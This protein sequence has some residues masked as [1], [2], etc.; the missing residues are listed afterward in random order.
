MTNKAGSY[1]RRTSPIDAN[2]K[3]PVQQA[4]VARCLGL[5]LTLLISQCT[6]LHWTEDV[7]VIQKL[8]KEFVW[9]GE[10][11][12]TKQS[13][14]W[15]LCYPAQSSSDS[16]KNGVKTRPQNNVTGEWN[17][18]GIIFDAQIKVVAQLCLNMSLF[19]LWLTLPR[20]RCL[21]F[22]HLNAW[23]RQPARPRVQRVLF[24]TWQPLASWTAV[25][26]ALC[27]G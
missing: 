21:F 18:H 10:G 2:R 3:D 26:L 5:Y 12:D 6:V 24:A 27:W 25:W 1:T 7:A 16:R 23:R 4:D 17:E 9:R 20:S 22:F 14:R 11:R 13:V 8:T 15:N 19:I